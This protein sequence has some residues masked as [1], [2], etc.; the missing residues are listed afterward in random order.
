MNVVIDTPT[1]HKSIASVLLSIDSNAYIYDN[2]NQQA[3]K[4]PAWF[5]I[6]REPVK[7]EREIGR[8][9]LIYSIDLFYMLEYN[10]PR[11]FDY[12][13]Q[14]ADSLNTSLI[15]LP[16][17]GQDYKTQIYEREW[18]LQLD[19]LKYSF[20]L[21]F[22]VSQDTVIDEKMQVIQDL[23]VFLKIKEKGG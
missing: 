6:H 12:Y 3:T 22:R 20:T 8:A 15:Y 16:I 23:S 5:I 14:I 18:G 11:L 19:A 4:L 10:I 13:A 7:I 21:R 17:Y 2:P 1:I 9:W